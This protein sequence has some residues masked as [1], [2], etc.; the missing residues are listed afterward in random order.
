MSIVYF[1]VVNP[2]AIATAPLTT[3][4]STERPIINLERRLLL[5]LLSSALPLGERLD[6]ILHSYLLSSKD[7]PSGESSL[8]EDECIALSS[9]GRNR[10]FEHSEPIWIGWSVTGRQKI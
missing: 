8:V 1:V 4:S 2:A 7:L 5:T 6:S 3:N 10:R 9:C